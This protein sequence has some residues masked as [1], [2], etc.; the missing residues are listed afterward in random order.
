M[1]IGHKIR[2]LRKENKLTLKELSKKTDLSISFISDIENERRNPRLD[3]LRKI[4][5]ALN[6]EVSE[7]LGESESFI[8]KENPSNYTVDE[9]E[10]E[11]ERLKPKIRQLPQEEKD[12]LFKMINAYLEE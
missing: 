1:N 10:I 7:L 11:I 4:A 2:E 6:V 12:K 9:L 8:I 5:S 3:N